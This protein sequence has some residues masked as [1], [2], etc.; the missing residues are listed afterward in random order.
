[1]CSVDP[2]RDDGECDNCN[3]TEQGQKEVE[4]AIPD[5]SLND[6]SPR[7]KCLG[8]EQQIYGVGDIKLSKYYSDISSSTSACLPRKLPTTWRQEWVSRGALFCL[9]SIPHS[10]I[11]SLAPGDYDGA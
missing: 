5:G 3:M 1:M 10:V 4:V 9:V 7:F 2:K 8:L 6:G 11:P